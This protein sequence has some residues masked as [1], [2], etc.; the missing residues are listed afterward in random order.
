MHA[1]HRWVGGVLRCLRDAP[2][3]VVP[4][5][6]RGHFTHCR[7]LCGKL[8]KAS[9]ALRPPR[10]NRPHGRKTNRRCG[11]SVVEHSLGKGKLWAATGQK[12]KGFSRARLLRGNARGSYLEGRDETVCCSS[13][14]VEHSLGKGEVESSI[15]SCSTI[16]SSEIPET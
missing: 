8:A 13:S 2:V 10:L 3:T 15:L 5:V 14:V 9:C 6:K 7:K 4:T 1:A 11:S 12:L 16:F